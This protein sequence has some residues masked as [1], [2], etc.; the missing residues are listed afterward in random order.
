MVAEVDLLK[1]WQLRFPL[2]KKGHI[3]FSLAMVSVA[4]LIG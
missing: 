3:S 4:I 1:V 2:Q